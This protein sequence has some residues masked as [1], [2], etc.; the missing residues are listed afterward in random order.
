MRRIVPVTAGIVAVG[1]AA[2]VTAS[3]TNAPDTAKRFTLVYNVNNA[4]Y[5]DVCGCKHKEVRQGSITRRASFLKQLRAA[6]PEILLLD[7]GSSLFPIEDRV[8]DPER[9]EAIR[10]AELIVEAYNRMGYRAMAVGSFDLAAGLDTLQSLAQKAKFEILS[11]NLLDKATQAPIFKPHAVLEVAG[12]RVGVI[13][14]TLETMSRAYL[15]KVAPGVVVS[16][17]IEAATRSVEELRGKVDLLIALS[18]VKQ[19]TN[20]QMISKLKELEIVVDPFI[21]YGN[22]KTWIDQDAWLSFRDDTLFLRS[23]GQGARMGVVDVTVIQSRKTLVQE[24]RLKELEEAMAAGKATA[25][26]KA[27]LEKAR[28]K[29]LIKFERISLEP[30]HRTDPDMDRL[31]EEWK[32]NIDPSKVAHLEAELPR[33][34][35]FLTVEKCKSCHPKQYDN[36]KQTKHSQAM[37]SLATTGDQHRYDCVGCHSLGYG[38]AF[39]NTTKIGAFADVQCESCHGTNAKHADDPKQ[40]KF[41]KVARSDCIVCHNKE[42]TRAE[43]N[44]VEAKPKVQCPKG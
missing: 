3:N 30:H 14:L 36:W 12:V 33:K 39:L 42:Q 25:E 13:G 43:F 10:K 35:D 4:G 41:S 9:V 22:P 16:D 24:D 7:G 40:F 27:E 23:D 19:E 18:H 11:A 28:G 34:A 15:G 29:N 5:I 26:E 17:P 6:K 37:A 31:I 8:K 1:L 44:F 32:K 38:E 2:L 21:E 20:F